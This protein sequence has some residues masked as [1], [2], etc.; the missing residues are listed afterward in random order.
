MRSTPHRKKVIFE[1][2]RNDVRDVIATAFDDGTPAKWI[3]FPVSNYASFSADAI[4]R[5]GHRVGMSMFAGYSWNARAVLSLGVV[6]A[7]V[8][9]LTLRWGEPE[10]TAKPSTEP[11]RQVP[12]RV[13]VAPL[14][15]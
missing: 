2:N 6:A 8:Q 1:W 12:I 3:D 9:V 15:G 5:D 13:K 4:P 11:H 14:R 7:D 10:P